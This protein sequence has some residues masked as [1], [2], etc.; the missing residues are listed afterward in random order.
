M[1]MDAVFVGMLIA[2]IGSGLPAVEAETMGQSPRSA[3]P[4]T[5]QPTCYDNSATGFLGP[6]GPSLQLPPWATSA[7]T[8]PQ[9]YATIQTG[10]IDGDGA[11]ELLGRGPA[12]LE[13]Y[14][15]SAAIGQW[16]PLLDANSNYL[17]GAG[18]GQ[19]G[20]SFFSDA[21][22]TTYWTSQPY[23]STIQTGDIDG[24]GA[25]EILARSMLGIVVFKWDKTNQGWTQLAPPLAWFS[26][27][28]GWAAPQYYS[29]IQTAD[30]DGDGSV[31]LLGRGAGGMAVFDWGS[32]GWNQLAGGG[33]FPDEV[34]SVP[35]GWDAPQY[36]S[37]IQTADL[38]G[39]GTAELLA[40]G[41]GG[42]QV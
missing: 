8:Q 18:L 20:T 4:T 39:N 33:P 38:D 42:M 25:D 17:V 3:S 29:T 5:P 11:A 15:F 10:D 6:C 9:Y 31:E 13:V 36:Y 24:D 37:T 22:G 35:T 7:F 16:Q 12:G 34:N 21:N 26:D 1:K 28:G 40:R 19:N 32:S 30:I 41:G 23:Y 14:K 2:V 27:A